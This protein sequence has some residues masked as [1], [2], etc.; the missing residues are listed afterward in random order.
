MDVFVIYNSYI[1]SMLF[2][3]IAMQGLKSYLAGGIHSNSELSS[4]DVSGM[5]AA[6]IFKKDLLAGT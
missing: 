2:T 3:H 1:K 5:Q 4:N 6:Q